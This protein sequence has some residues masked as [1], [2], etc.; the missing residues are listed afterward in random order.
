MALSKGLCK[1]IMKGFAKLQC[2]K[3]LC[4]AFSQVDSLVL[5]LGIGKKKSLIK[6]V[7]Y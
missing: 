2:F 3:G 1:G 5:D 6:V 4:E 7:I